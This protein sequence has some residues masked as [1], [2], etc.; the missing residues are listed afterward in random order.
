MSMFA[1]LNEMTTDKD[2]K[3][4][5]YDRVQTSLGQSGSPLI[6]KL[7]DVYQII[8]V[9][10]GSDQGYNLGTFIQ[11]LTYSTFSQIFSKEEE[12]FK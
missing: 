1:S 4:I 10:T 7:N 3:I 11:S 5:K 12:K 2:G 9:H 8:G 6:L